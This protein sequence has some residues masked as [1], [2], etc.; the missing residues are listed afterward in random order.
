MNLKH[1]KAENSIVLIFWWIDRDKIQFWDKV[2]GH[3]KPKVGFQILNSSLFKVCS[4]LII[5]KARHLKRSNLSI[6]LINRNITTYLVRIW[7]TYSNWNFWRN[8][9][10]SSMTAFFVF[11]SNLFW[12]LQSSID[13]ISV[14]E[15]HGYVCKVIIFW[16]YW[17]Y[18]LLFE[19]FTDFTDFFSRD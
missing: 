3:W 17:I 9:Y 19:C 15:I 8:F 10:F 13:F 18:N 4:G 1:V 7:E 12:I 14:P 11:L 2:I 16:I 5:A 6:V